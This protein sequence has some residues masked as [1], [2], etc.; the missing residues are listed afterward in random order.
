MNR[1]SHCLLLLAA[2]TLATCADG[3]TPLA[4]P[5]GASL[6]SA[7][8]AALEESYLVRFNGPVPAR[9]AERVAGL[10]GS[11]IFVHGGAGIGAVAG[12]SPRAAAEL[13]ALPGVGAVAADDATVLE[14]ETPALASAADPSSAWGFPMQWNLRAIGAPGAWAAGRL[15]SPAVR[16]AILDTGLDYEHPELAGRVDLAASRSFVPSED[17]LVAASFPGAH[18]VADIHYHGTMVGATVSSNGIRLAGVTSGVTLVGLKVCRIDGR[19]PV[20][21]V[22]S[23]VLYAADQGIDVANLS[24]GTSFLRRDSSAAHVDGPSFVSIVNRAFTYAHRK[25]LTVVAASGNQAVDVDHDGN[26]FRTY[27]SAPNVICVSATGPTAAATQIGPFT[28]VDAPAPYSNHGRSVISVAAPG[29]TAAAYAW[30][31]CS[32][33]SILIP[34][35]RTNTDLM[36]GGL[37]TS[38]SAPHVAAA[39]ALVAE[40]VGREPSRIRA[41]LE[42]TADDLGQPGTDPHYG[43][44][45]LNVA[46]AVGAN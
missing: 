12:L 8:V 33:F 44:G 36:L 42:Q 15:G 14:A 40:D 20:S 3:D 26:S 19:C 6:S 35:C 22:L 27:C 31:P 10:G 25:G 39:A 17:A 45:R 38:M 34:V 18:P 2:G 1:Y 9:F 13:G 16:V 24:L 28:D 46:R 43:K 5:P 41:R 11:V 29:G 7:A 23:A 4:P 32:T 21:G 37:G 30:A